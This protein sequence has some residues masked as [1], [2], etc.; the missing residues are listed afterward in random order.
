MQRRALGWIDMPGLV[1]MLLLTESSHCPL[2]VRD[3][4]VR[5]LCAVSRLFSAICQH[6]LT[7]SPTCLTEYKMTLTFTFLDDG[8]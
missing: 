2:V 7:G 8:L 4:T 1:V 5:S 3:A 6:F